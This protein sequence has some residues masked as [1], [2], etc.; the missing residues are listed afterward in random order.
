VTTAKR[1]FLKA[2]SPHI[3]ATA[4]GTLKNVP[5]AMKCTI[6]TLR[7]S[8]NKST[9]NNKPAPIAKRLSQLIYLKLTRRAVPRNPNTVNTAI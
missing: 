9:I 7:K 1:T 8:T 2:R 3:S 6:S 5:I 4:A